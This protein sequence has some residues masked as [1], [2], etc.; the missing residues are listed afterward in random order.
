MTASPA[1]KRPDLN[2]FLPPEP[3]VRFDFVLP[4]LPARFP[5]SHSLHFYDDTYTSNQHEHLYLNLRRPSILHGLD[6]PGASGFIPLCLE[7]IRFLPSYSEAPPQE[8]DDPTELAFALCCHKVR[9]NAPATSDRPHSNHPPSPTALALIHQHHR[10]QPAKF[11]GFLITLASLLQEK[12]YSPL[13]SLDCR[14]VN[15]TVQAERR[16][17][18]PLTQPD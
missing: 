3:S 2:A 15:A 13:S 7:L 5:A 18:T 12:T 17:K 4:Q 6:R 11:S 16:S 8:S 10:G 9:E 14:P 1:W